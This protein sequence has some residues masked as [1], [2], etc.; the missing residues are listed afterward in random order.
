MSK[1]NAIQKGLKFVSKTSDK[2]CFNCKW[3]LQSNEAEGHCNN[4]HIMVS[5]NQ[6]C[7]VW[8]KGHVG[9]N[10]NMIR[11][12]QQNL[13]SSPPYKGHPKSHIPKPTYEDYDSKYIQRYFVRYGSSIKN[14]II[15]VSEAAYQS[16]NNMFYHTLELKW[17]IS[18]PEKTIIKDGVTIDKGIADAN[19]DTV[20]LKNRTFV[21]IKD[22]LVDYT[23]LAYRKVEKSKVNLRSSKKKK[24]KSVYGSGIRPPI[25]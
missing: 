9:E 25:K 10:Q 5:K 14:P 23:E 21:G 18:G 6:L 13:L 19:R 7:N 4:F 20:L 17:K 22:Y 11:E 16:V 1:N 2:R 24:R 8:V 15:E 12:Y 3:F